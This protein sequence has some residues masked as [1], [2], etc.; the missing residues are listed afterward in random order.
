MA[1]HL[2]LFFYS[3]CQRLKKVKGQNVKFKIKV[4]PLTK[5]GK[6]GLV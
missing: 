1:R 5:T 2:H 3:I 6:N 4:I